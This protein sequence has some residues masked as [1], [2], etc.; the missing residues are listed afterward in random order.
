MTRPPTKNLAKKLGAIAAKPEQE[1]DRASFLN[2]IAKIMESKGI[3]MDD[4][5][6]IKKI[7]SYQT[8]TKNEEG[9][10]EVHD[11]WALQF[12][13]A[14]ETGPQWPVIT[15]GPS[16]NLPKSTVK[17]KAK[18]DFKTC[19][20]VPDIQFG[21]YRQEDFSLVPTHDERAISICLQVIADLQPELVVCVGDNIDFPEFGKYR[22]SPAFAGTTQASIDRAT[23]FA[24]EM[25]NA[26]PH[27]KIVW[28]AGNHEERLPNYILDNAKAAFG[29]RKGDTPKSWPVMSVPSLCRF[30]E[31]KIQYEP[32][33]PAGN[34]WINEKLRVVHGHKVKSNGSTAH[35]YLS[36]EK[37][38]VIYGHIH[39]IEV[40]FKTRRDYD[41]ARTIMAA[42]PG[43]LARI[44][45]AVPSTIGGLD[46]DGRPLTVV[47][48]WQQGLG[49]VTY[50]DKGD[51]KFSYE[52]MP[53]YNGWGIFRGT[54]YNAR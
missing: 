22:L 31:Y 13:P 19:V 28:L 53:I 2:S 6:Q 23:V 49:V 18:H 11:L 43:C 8:I 9:E 38:S 32:G 46:L 52:T 17:K 21:Y 54:E 33:Y 27:A 39:R 14:F 10:A 47:E 5:G 42:S 24:A 48:N 35:M 45:G 25:R 37:T 7:S 36:S 12:S 44:D 29:L 34:F 20:I 4:I 1:R 15:P 16:V 51:H 3:S 50:E 30:D 41:G 26:A 40:A